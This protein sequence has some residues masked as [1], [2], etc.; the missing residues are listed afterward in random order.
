MVWTPNRKSVRP[1]FACIAGPGQPGP[2][3]P[4]PPS[5]N[6]AC[7]FFKCCFTS[8]E[9][10]QTIRG[11][12]PRTAV[13]TFTQILSSDWRAVRCASLYVLTH[14]VNKLT[15]GEM[16][17]CAL[18]SHRFCPHPVLPRNEI[19]LGKCEGDVQCYLNLHSHRALRLGRLGHGRNINLRTTMPGGGG[20][21]YCLR[22]HAAHTSVS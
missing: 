20:V 2:S 9:T 4:S 18:N 16:D 15:E 13:S 11:G 6:L 17:W 12:D 3:S 7:I 1:V 22:I 14:S 19:A 5:R 8:A 21:V 10:I